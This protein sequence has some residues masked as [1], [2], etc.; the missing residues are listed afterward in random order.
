V[1]KVI[2]GAIVVMLLA[3]I[4]FVWLVAFGVVV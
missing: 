3:V 1:K 2:D 4:V